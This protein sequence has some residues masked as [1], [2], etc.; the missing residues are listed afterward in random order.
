MK[1]NKI[2]LIIQAVG[3]YVMHIPLYIL[4]VLIFLPIESETVSAWTNYLLIAYLILLAIVAPICLLNAIISIIS[5][6]KGKE[7]PAR[8]VMFVKLALI[9]WYIM[10]FAMCGILLAG[11]LNPF[12]MLAIP[13]AMAIMIMVTYMFMISTSI[14]DITDLIRLLI[15]RKVKISAALVFATI[16]LFIFTLDIVG[17][18]MYYF[19]TKEN[20]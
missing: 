10:N 14:P 12:L 3:M 19:L 17:G 7:S 5:I 18:V 16:F 15:R 6:V 11:F 2:T 4:F 1:F 13:I 8:C 9:P 20:Q